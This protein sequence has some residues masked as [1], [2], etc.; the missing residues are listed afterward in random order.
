MSETYGKYPEGGLD[1]Q[2]IFEY[3]NFYPYYTSAVDSS[4][5]NDKKFTEY[6]S[7]EDLLFQYAAMLMMTLP[8]P[9]MDSYESSDFA[10]IKGNVLG[11]TDKIIEALGTFPVQAQNAVLEEM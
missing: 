7:Q 8:E 2:V 10:K 11:Y 5:N 9:R 3:K 4:Y 6:L 1:N